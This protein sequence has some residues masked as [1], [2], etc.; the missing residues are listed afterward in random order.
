MASLRLN[1]LAINEPCWAINYIELVAK[2]EGSKD[3][4]LDPRVNDEKK[5][6]LIEETCM[7]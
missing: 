6:E 5:V 1:P 7:F 4:D 3:L 2:T